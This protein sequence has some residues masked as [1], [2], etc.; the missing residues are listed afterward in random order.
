[1]VTNPRQGFTLQRKTSQWNPSFQTKTTSGEVLI[2]ILT[3]N[4]QI[5]VILSTVKTTGV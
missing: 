4:K 5:V 2:L 1:M 3:K